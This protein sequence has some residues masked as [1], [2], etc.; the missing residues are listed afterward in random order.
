MTT[1]E[2]V[3]ADMPQAKVISVFDANSGY[4]QVKLD[5]V[6][7]QLCTF[8]KPFERYRFTRLPFGIK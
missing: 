5:E 8:N 3:A 7:S 4:W 2:D 1:K 6:S